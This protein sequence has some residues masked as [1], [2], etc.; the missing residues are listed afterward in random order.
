MR[1]N[2]FGRG[3]LP[4]QRLEFPPPARVEV[5]RRFVQNEY[6]RLARQHARQTNAALL[7]MAQMMRGAPAKTGQ[8]DLR[9]RLLDT[10]CDF[11]ITET[12]LLRA[13]GHVFLNGRAK[14]LVIRVLKHQT[15]L[16]ANGFKVFRRD[17][18]T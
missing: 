9:Q 6:R 16:S 11:N 18:F 12:E 2:Q 13:E 4:Q 3:N 15:D 5:A 14:K 8:P 17:R 7:A 1:R 10:H